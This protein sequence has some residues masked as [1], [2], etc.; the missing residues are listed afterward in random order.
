MQLPS[1]LPSGLFAALS[2]IFIA[3]AIVAMCCASRK[4][5]AEPGRPA[6]GGSRTPTQPD[7]EFRG[8]FVTTAYNKDWPSRR[9]LHKNMQR[10]EMR[11]VVRRAK[12]LNCNVIILQVRAFGDRIY[13]KTAL[14]VDGKKTRWAMSLDF[15]N[16]PGYDPLG[17]WID[18]CH[19]EGLLL[20]AWINPFRIDYA[21]GDLPFF[22]AKD[23][24]LYLDL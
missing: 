11:A 7:A 19:N 13:A 3:I 18:A 14:E 23:G 17:E 8:M 22:A 15:T 10:N 9:G 24:D 2:S 1:P 4:G 12:E 6:P 5:H 16:D 20:Y 21:I